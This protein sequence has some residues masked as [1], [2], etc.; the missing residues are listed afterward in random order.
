MSGYQIDQV[1]HTGISIVSFP[2]EEGRRVDLDT[3]RAFF[4]TQFFDETAEAKHL[5]IDLDGVNT[6]DSSS[7]SP[8]VQR[9]REL[10]ERQGTMVLC[11]IKSQGLREILS[12]TRFDRIFD[13]YD[14]QQ[15]ALQAFNA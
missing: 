6:L 3:V 8:L 12:L 11:G 1:E 4:T 15:K 5:V 7:L 14:D 9:Y 2:H 13:I 10:Q